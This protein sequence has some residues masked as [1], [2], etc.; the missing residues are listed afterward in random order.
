MG[1]V[2]VEGGPRPCGCSARP[3]VDGARLSRRAVS[4]TSCPRSHGSAASAGRSGVARPPMPGGYRAVTPS[5]H[6]SAA[7]VPQRRDSIRGV[8]ETG[9]DSERVRE[10]VASCCGELDAASRAFDEAGADTTFEHGQSTAQPG[11][12]EVQAPGRL[13][14]VKVPRYCCEAHEQVDPQRQQR[15]IEHGRVSSCLGHMTRAHQ[16][17]HRS[18][19]VRVNSS[20]RSHPFQNQSY[21]YDS[22]S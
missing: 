13:R 18:P 3:I 22:V 21:H 5:R 2:A 12:R 15:R 6:C 19:V 14:E 11:L 8:P 1:R 20:Y 9:E 10:E 16:V 17:W 7:S 4:R